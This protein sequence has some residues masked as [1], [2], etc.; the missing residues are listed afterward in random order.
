MASVDPGTG[1]KVR[2]SF[3]LLKFFKFKFVCS[4]ILH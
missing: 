2:L 3:F 1:I 4:Q